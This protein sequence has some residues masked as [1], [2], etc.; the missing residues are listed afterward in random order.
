M[1]L[2]EQ[3][4]VVA[5]QPLGRGALAQV[6]GLHGQ[7]HVAQPL[8]HGGQGLGNG[9]HLAAH[10]AD[11]VLLAAVQLPAEI[12]F[13]N[14]PGKGERAAHGPGDAHGKDH[15]EQHGQ[16]QAGSGHDHGRP[17]QVMV[18]QR[19]VFTAPVHL[20]PQLRQ[21]LVQP[22]HGRSVPGVYPLAHG[23]DLF[24]VKGTRIQKR[25]QLLFQDVHKGDVGLANLGRILFLAQDLSQLFEK[26][27]VR[28]DQPLHLHHLLPRFRRIPVNDGV[29]E[30]RVGELH[31]GIDMQQFHHVV[32][33]PSFLFLQLG[34]G[35]HLVVLKYGKSDK[36]GGNESK[37]H[38]QAQPNWNIR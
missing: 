10:L 29:G 21:Q 11:L 2:P 24:L 8:G 5:L 35:R 30:Q 33:Q 32:G 17:D 1:P 15:G 27:H 12:P 20:R 3:P 13:G 28:I 26:K 6:P 34:H 18:I 7:D 23:R 16:E 36:H 19:V 4:L 14:G 9:G 38:Q 22:F 25:Q 31:A 37:G